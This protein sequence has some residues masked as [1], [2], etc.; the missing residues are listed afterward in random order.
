[1]DFMAIFDRWFLLHFWVTFF[2]GD[3]SFTLLQA[4][5]I[6]HTRSDRVDYVV[7]VCVSKNDKQLIYIGFGQGIRRSVFSVAAILGPLWAGGSLVFS[8]YYI[9]L[10][11]PC[12]LLLFILVSL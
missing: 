7:C 2:Y 1:M 3:N 10:G 9:L 5:A 6:L 4:F 8:T 12:G 11:V